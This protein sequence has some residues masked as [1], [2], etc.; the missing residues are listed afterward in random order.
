MS[1][2]LLDAVL[3]VSSKVQLCNLSSNFLALAL[4]E[5]FFA[6]WEPDC[7]VWYQLCVISSAKVANCY[8]LLNC[9]N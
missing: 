2:M 6:G 3:I 8:L 5:W 1:P 7:E 4:L 9:L